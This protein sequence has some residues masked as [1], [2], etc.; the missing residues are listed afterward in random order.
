MSGFHRNDEAFV[1]FTTHS[2]NKTT[3]TSIVTHSKIKLHFSSIDACD[4]AQNP[5]WTSE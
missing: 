1:S 4:H 2:F 3:K 5:Y